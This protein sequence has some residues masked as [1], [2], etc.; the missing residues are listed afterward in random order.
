MWVG[1]SWDTNQIPS[2]TTEGWWIT[3][4]HKNVSSSTLISWSLYL[5]YHVLH[6]PPHISVTSQS[7]RYPCAM[8]LL[9]PVFPLCRIGGLPWLDWKLAYPIGWDVLMGIILC[10]LFP[11]F[12]SGAGLSLGSRCYLPASL[13]PVPHTITSSYASTAS[14]AGSGS[15][16][17]P[18]WTLPAGQQP[19][20]CAGFRVFR[21]W[22]WG[23]L[24]L[25]DLGPGSELGPPPILA[26]A[27]IW[28]SGY[29]RR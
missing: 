17:P 26:G 7:T 12:R 23:H 29:M 22:L 21:C 16:G 11:P 28:R 1:I 3:P 5:L 8:L 20:G 6:P 9:V 14:A 2:L 25:W 27:K 13:Y 18:A 10:P 4:T 19:Y 15:G 24:S